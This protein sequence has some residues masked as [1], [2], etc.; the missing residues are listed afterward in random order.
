MQIIKQLKAAA[1]RSTPKRKLKLVT[2]Q[3]TLADVWP[4]GKAL[5][6]FKLFL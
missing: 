1:V 6:A 4:Q 2:R 3:A 5:P